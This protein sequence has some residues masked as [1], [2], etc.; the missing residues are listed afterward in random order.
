[1]GPWKTEYWKKRIADYELHITELQSKKD[2]WT[3][4][5]K[6]N[7]LSKGRSME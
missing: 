4:S 2:E 5:Y 1:M 7:Q 6:R 3:K